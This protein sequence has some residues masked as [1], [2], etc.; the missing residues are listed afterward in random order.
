MQPPRRSVGG[1]GGQCVARRIRLAGDGRLRIGGELPPALASR[2][3][4]SGRLVMRE[5]SSSQEV[6]VALTA[7]VD[8]RGIEGVVDLARLAPA[9][10]GPSAWDVYVEL[11]ETARQLLLVAADVALA[12]ACVVRAERALHRICPYVTDRGTL[13]L[14]STPLRIHAEVRRVV[15]ERGAVDI[16]GVLVGT[17]AWPAAGAE[18]VARRRRDGRAVRCAAALTDDRCSARLQLCELTANG[19]DEEVWDLELDLGG[20]AGALRLGA[21]LDDVPNK[22]QVMIYPPWRAAGA[23]VQRELRPYFTVEN[24]LSIRSVAVRSGAAQAAAAAPVAAAEGDP[25]L[26]ARARRRAAVM[27]AA[28]VQKVAALALRLALARGRRGQRPARHADGARRK[29]HVLLMH[30][31]GMGGTIRTTLNLVEYLAERHDVEL[32]SV[33]RRRDQPFFAFPGGVTV[34][35]LDDRRKSTTPSGLRGLLR[36]LLSASPSLLLHPDDY[37]FATCNL[38]TDLLMTR[39]IRALAPGVLMTT[40]PAFNLLATELAP[41]GLVTIGQE[42]MNFNAHRPALAA[43]I[44]RQ[45]SRLDALAV[46][47]RD[48]LRDYGEILST[49][50]TRVVQIPNALPRLEGEPSPLRSNVVIAAGRLTWQKGFDLLIAAFV[51]VAREHPDWKL[52]I[53]GGGPKRGRLRR[54]ILEHELYNDVFLM[55]ATE[56]LGDELAKASLFALSSRYEGFGMVIVEAMSKGLPVVSFD[57]PRGPSE[58]IT[59]GRDGLLVAEGDVAAFADALLQLIADEQRRRR[60]GAAAVE[61]ARTFDIAAIGPRWEALIEELAPVACAAGGETRAARS[62]RPPGRYARGAR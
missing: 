53:Y 41:P 17:V 28:A 60:Y 10:G 39:K 2:A 16:D 20:D 33:V 22:K 44:R 42:H 37:A 36:R 29:V 59:H 30:A 9:A 62:R 50:H 54:L 13:S 24:N 51:Q 57:C 35:T 14:E 6:G 48:D 3:G 26:R 43:E 25:R 11:D 58:I 47:T 55:G 40:R 56:Q 31:Y 4:R 34:T 5:R 38:W 23:G 52:R 27:L 46:L 1:D 32:I 61:K 21:H 49:A 7:A 19:D 12:P 15:A 8:G 45:Y 18:L